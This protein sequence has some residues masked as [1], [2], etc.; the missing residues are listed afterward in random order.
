MAEAIPREYWSDAEECTERVFYWEY[1]VQRWLV[2]GPTVIQE[3]EQPEGDA[4]RTV[5]PAKPSM[6]DYGWLMEPDSCL[7][8]SH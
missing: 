1:L 6:H 8:S 3:P 5:T 4:P 2:P 7:G